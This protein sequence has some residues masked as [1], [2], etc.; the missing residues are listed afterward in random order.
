MEDFST[1]P[2]NKKHTIDTAMDSLWR[3]YST[4]F[5]V[6]FLISF[7]ASVAVNFYTQTIDLD[8]LI[9]SAQ[10]LQTEPEYLAEYLDVLKQTLVEMIPV[11]ILLI[12]VNVLLSLYVLRNPSEGNNIPGYFIGS[13]KYFLTYLIILILAIPLILLALAAG[14][15]AVFVGIFFSMIWLVALLAFILPFLMAEGNDITRAI[16]GSFRLMHSKFWNNI[17]WTAV[18]LVVILIMSFIL[19]GLALI[20]FA[21]SFMKTLAN[22]E[23]V[24]PIIE[25]GKNPIYILMSAALSSLITPLYPIFSFILYFNGKSREN[26]VQA[27]G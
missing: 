5:F 6:L 18:L 7:L 3:F 2:L 10:R 21:G 13:F 23:E 26:I 20:P 9:G 14:L 25:L 17:G 16:T 11:F 12:F 24:T 22:P 4:H 27:A 1:H 15:L 8:K 19:S